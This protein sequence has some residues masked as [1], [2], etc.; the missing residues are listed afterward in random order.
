MKKEKKLK[1]VNNIT[2]LQNKYK[3]I[4]FLQW[5]VGFTDG[6]GC[7]MIKKNN[8]FMFQIKLHIDE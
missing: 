3:N 6:E 4:Y 8:T 5:L 7:F 1:N 2:S